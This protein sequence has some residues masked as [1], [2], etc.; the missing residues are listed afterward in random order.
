MAVRAEAFNYQKGRLTLFSG[1]NIFR[2][3]WEHWSHD[4]RRN[5]VATTAS[6]RATRGGASTDSEALQA[7]LP[8]EDGGADSG[9]HAVAA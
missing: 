2:T 9:R 4:L 1:S 8:A 5:L 6:T 7:G 3:R